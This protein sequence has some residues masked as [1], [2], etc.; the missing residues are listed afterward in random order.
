M[1][2]IENLKKSFGGVCAVNNCSFS[3][4]KGKITALIGPNGSGKSTVFN[5]I[6]GVLSSD[7]GKI[8]LDGKEITNKSVNEISNLGVSRVFQQSRMFSN[9]TVKENLLL[10]LREGDQSFWKNLLGLNRE[11]NETKVLEILKLVGLES[12]IS[13]TSRELSFGQKRLVE[14]SR[15]ILKPHKLLMLDEPVAGVTPPMRKKISELIIELKKQGETVLLIE[16]DMQFTLT[17]ADEVIVL[18]EGKVIAKGVPAQ[19]KRNKKV[20]EAYLGD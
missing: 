16:H 5:L 4:S 2:K 1:L 18:D 6:C 14:I 11:D 7:N 19:I 9:L 10:A 3:V 17:L 20:L 13:A 12:K 15:A 8:F